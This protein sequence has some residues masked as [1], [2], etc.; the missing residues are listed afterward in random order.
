MNN[1]YITLVSDDMHVLHLQK[2]EDMT[3][4][5]DHISM[6]TLWMDIDDASLID[7][8]VYSALANAQR[9]DVISLKDKSYRVSQ[10]S[11]NKPREIS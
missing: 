5:N 1:L 10:I 3:K 8:S 9:G 4:T 11:Y 7:F 2:I 6:N